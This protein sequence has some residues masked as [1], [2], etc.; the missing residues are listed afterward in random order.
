MNQFL[1]ELK[2]EPLTPET[3]LDLAGGHFQDHL[4]SRKDYRAFFKTMSTATA[5]RDLNLGV[6]EKILKRS[7]DKALARYQFL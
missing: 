7:G 6:E 4:F 1:L 3:R 5:S 2:P